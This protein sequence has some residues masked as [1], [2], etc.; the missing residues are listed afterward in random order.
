[1]KARPLSY[2]SEY[3]YQYTRNSEL[4]YSHYSNLQHQQTNSNTGDR[5]WNTVKLTSYTCNMVPSRFRRAHTSPA[6][7]ANTSTHSRVALS[8]GCPLYRHSSQAMQRIRAL[9]ASCAIR[10][11]QP[12]RRPP[13][14]PR[15]NFSSPAMTPRCSRPLRVAPRLLRPYLPT[16]CTPF[17]R[18]APLTGHQRC[19][20]TSHPLEIA[21]SS[22]RPA[23][24]GGGGSGCVWHG[25]CGPEAEPRCVPTSA[26]IPARIR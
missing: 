13:Y 5:P 4:G 11:W 25:Q 20:T 14:R 18:H 22:A 7:R 21:L 19:L 9:C 17:R 10:S 6:N 12:W 8:T 15:S 23:T 3:S 24:S 16:A 1:M 26:Q 2:R